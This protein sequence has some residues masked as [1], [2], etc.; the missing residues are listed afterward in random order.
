MGWIKLI[1]ILIIINLINEDILLLF[2]NSLLNWISFS[3]IFLSLWDALLHN[4][5]ISLHDFLCNKCI[6]EGFDCG[7][8]CISSFLFVLYLI[9]LLTIF[10]F[11]LDLLKGSI[12]FKKSLIKS[13]K[14]PIWLIDAFL[15]IMSLISL[16]LFLNI[17]LSLSYFKIS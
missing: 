12:Y 16:L 7:L 9:L 5:Y 1:I 17:L 11:F 13:F 8:F 6:L 15:I 4:L 14:L 10:F 2:L 3:R